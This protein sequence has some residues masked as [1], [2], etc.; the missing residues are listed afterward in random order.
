MPLDLAR[1]RHT[2]ATLWPEAVGVV[3]DAVAA[4]DFTRATYRNVAL[5]H[6]NDGPILF[7]GDAAHGTSPQL[8]QGA[9]LGLVDAWTLAQ[10]VE[11]SD[12]AAQA[13]GRFVVRRSATVRFYRQASH[14]LTPFFQ[15]NL[16]PLGWLRDAFMIL[17]CR[18]PVLR[19]IAATTLAGTRSGW[20]SSVRLDGEG[21]Y[22]LDKAAQRPGVRP[23]RAAK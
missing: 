16:P 11:E 9:N 12:S 3:A 5:P 17:A 20:L 18:L 6:W 4:N 10:A 19:T 8:G 15:S 2:T 14:L 23:N 13:I 1:L 22:A 7:I 21:R